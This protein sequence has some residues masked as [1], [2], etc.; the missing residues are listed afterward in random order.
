MNQKIVG[1][2]PLIAAMMFVAVFAVGD[3]PA[4]AANTASQ[5]ASVN[6]PDVISIEVPT[7]VS[8]SW[9]SVDA[10]TDLYLLDGANP[11]WVKS[12]SNGHIDVAISSTGTIG[13]AGTSDTLT[14]F[15][16]YASTTKTTF[17]GSNQAAITDW[18]V[19]QNGVDG[20]DNVQELP[21]SVDV[22]SF[23]SNGNYQTTVTYTASRHL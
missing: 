19:A 9:S 4:A 12:L 16:F 1:I 17:D 20:V 21:L 15:G 13:A 18:K 6:V 8:N 22:P 23:T 10:K 3:N 2:I 7:S 5:T 11:N 14:N